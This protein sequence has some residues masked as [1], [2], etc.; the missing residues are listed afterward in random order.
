MRPG[1]SARGENVPMG[2]RLLVFLLPL[3]VLTPSGASA[4]PPTVPIVL[5]VPGMRSEAC[6][7][8]VRSKLKQ[9]P[10]VTSVEFNLKKGKVY[11][12]VGRG[13]EQYVALEHS[14]EDAGG[15]IHMFHPTYLV[16]QA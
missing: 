7:A 16:P 3:L 8:A 1:G 4:A 13:F 15:A 9:F 2:F 12:Q 10:E 14:L 6:V 5:D 11:L